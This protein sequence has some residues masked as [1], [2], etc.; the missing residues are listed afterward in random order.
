VAALLHNAGSLIV[1]FNSARLVRKGEEME[2][3]QP[4]IARPAPPHAVPAPQ[5]TPGLA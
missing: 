5:L 4:A 2:H 1:I 3:F